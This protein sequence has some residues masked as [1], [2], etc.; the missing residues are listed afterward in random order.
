MRQGKGNLYTQPDRFMNADAAMA[1]IV[2]T[3]REEH[4]CL[5][6]VSTFASLV[7]S[8]TKSR[9]TNSA[10]E[11]G[12]TTCMP[13]LS[14]GGPVRA[15]RLCRFCG[16]KHSVIDLTRIAGSSE[17]VL[18]RRKRLRLPATDASDAWHRSSSA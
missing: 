15:E 2:Q 16:I 3:L 18:T 12:G 9:M 6:R 14:M 10:L 5:L 1:E 13:L 11:Q 7:V 8:Y 4:S 17:L